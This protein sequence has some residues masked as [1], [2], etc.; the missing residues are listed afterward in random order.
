VVCGSA[1]GS[2]IL[3]RRIHLTR[4]ELRILQRLRV[5]K[6]EFSVQEVTVRI[7]SNGAP[8]VR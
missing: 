3:Q 5:E 2:E 6:R 7:A 4:E 1:G 8:L